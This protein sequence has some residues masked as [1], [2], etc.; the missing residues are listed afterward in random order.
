MP[1]RHRSQ[2]GTRDTDEFLTDMPET[3]S[4]QGRHGG[5]IAREVATRDAM[6]RATTQGARGVTRVGKSQENQ[7]GNRNGNGPGEVIAPDGEVEGPGQGPS[8]SDQPLDPAARSET[9]RSDN[10]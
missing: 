5:D 6:L 9:M 7:G 1:E 2:D 10:S 8:G 3:P 4:F